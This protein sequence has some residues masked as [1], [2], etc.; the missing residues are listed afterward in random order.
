M[1]LTT[2]HIGEKG[3]TDFNISSGATIALGEES[4]RYNLQN[5]GFNHLI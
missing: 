2:D 4:T 1:F 5:Y 3:E